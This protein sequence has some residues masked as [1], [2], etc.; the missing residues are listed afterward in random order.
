MTEWVSQ[1]DAVKLLASDGDAIS[2]PALSQYLNGHQE[3]PRQAGGPG[4]P[5]MIDLEAL[6][7]SRATRRSRGPASGPTG[8]LN[9]L[10]PPPAPEPVAIDPDAAAH[11]AMRTGFADRKSQA[12]VQRAEAEARLSEIR[13]RAAAGDFI[14]KAEAVAFARAVAVAL[15]KAMEQRRHVAISEIRAAKDPR[16]AAMAMEK[17]EQAIRAALASALADLAVADDPQTAA[18]Q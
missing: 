14:A 18:A 8:E 16:E 7:S 5:T 9:L 2:Q 10:P 11:S 3:I 1:G 12:D 17:H 6:R 15:V 4:R 13:A